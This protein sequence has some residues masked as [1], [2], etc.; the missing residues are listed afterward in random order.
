MPFSFLTAGDNPPHEINV[1]I[2]ITKG[3]DPVKYE[4]DKK[5]GLLFVDRF[6][7]TP[8]FY[9]GNYGFITGTLSGD[10]DPCDALLVGCPPVVPGAIA[11]CRPLGVLVMEDEKGLDEKIICVPVGMLEHIKEYKGLSK[12]TQ[13]L[14]EHFFMHYKDLDEGKWTK[15]IRWGGLEESHQFIMDGIRRHKEM[16]GNPE[17]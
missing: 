1:F 12:E 10:G 7:K 11:R 8:M 4:V 13:N 6:L 15:I 3:V 9:P 16:R 14:V 17:K 5:T 2:E